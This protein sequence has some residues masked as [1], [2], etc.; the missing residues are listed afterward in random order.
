[1]HSFIFTTLT[2]IYWEFC[3]N[4]FKR[5]PLLGANIFYQVHFLVPKHMYFFIH[6]TFSGLEQLKPSCDLSFIRLSDHSHSNNRKCNGNSKVLNCVI[7]RCSTCIHTAGTEQLPW[8]GNSA[9]SAEF[10]L[11]RQKSGWLFSVQCTMKAPSNALLL[12]PR[13]L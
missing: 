6:I 4:I 7:G 3:L 11:V 8:K 13:T 10:I 12:G 5:Q 2:R 9:L 1:M